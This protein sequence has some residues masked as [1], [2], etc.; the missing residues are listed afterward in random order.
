MQGQD[1]REQTQHGM[2]STG[3]LHETKTCSKSKVQTGTA[4]DARKG[5]ESVSFFPWKTWNFV[6]EYSIYKIWNT[7]DF[8]DF[9]ISKLE[10][11]LCC[12]CLALPDQSVEFLLGILLALISSLKA[13]L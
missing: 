2:V 8:M 1:I 6:R 9:H 5:K 12:L 4:R 7:E 3:K 10:R 13:D 11:L